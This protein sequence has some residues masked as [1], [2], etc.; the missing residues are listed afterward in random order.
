MFCKNSVFRTAVS[1]LSLIKLQFLRNLRFLQF[2]HSH[3]IPETF[4][5]L[6]R[7]ANLC[8]FY[9]SISSSCKHD[10]ANFYQHWN[11]SN[12][13]SDIYFFISY[14]P[15][16]WVELQRKLFCSL[17]NKTDYGIKK[18]WFQDHEISWFKLG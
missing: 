12:F 5:L 7:T 18:F 15:C 6:K 13:V 9:A 4:Q 10:G 17:W 14:G 16:L 2:S 8:T 1:V 3:F 11:Y